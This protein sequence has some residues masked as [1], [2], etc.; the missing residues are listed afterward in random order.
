MQSTKGLIDMM[1]TADT[2]A[3]ENKKKQVQLL[4]KAIATKRLEFPPG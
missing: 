1:H 3:L 2:E 4:Q